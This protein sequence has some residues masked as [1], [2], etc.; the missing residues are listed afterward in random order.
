MQKYRFS[1]F[2]HPIP[3]SFE[4][5]QGLYNILPLFLKAI[6]LFFIKSHIIK[7]F[8]PKIN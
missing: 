3:V 4:K 6:L 7:Y 2:N 1:H 5:F 8:Y